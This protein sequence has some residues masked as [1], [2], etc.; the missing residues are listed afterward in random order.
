MD[1]NE[2]EPCATIEVEVCT[3]LMDYWVCNGHRLPKYHA[4]V[5]DEHGIWGCGCTVEEAIC[6]MMMSHKE[7][8]VGGRDAMNIRYIGVAGR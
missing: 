6:D 4:S 2:S 1:R 3:R 7:N 5:A 8:F